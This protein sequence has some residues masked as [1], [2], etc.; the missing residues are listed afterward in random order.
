MVY[1]NSKKDSEEKVISDAIT[2]VVVPDDHQ[3]I[4]E[5]EVEIPCHEGD[6]GQQNKGTA[7]TGDEENAITKNTVA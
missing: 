1:K 5:K 7:V 2:V 3:I 4:K 6:H